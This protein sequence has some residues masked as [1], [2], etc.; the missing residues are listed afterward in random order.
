MIVLQRLARAAPQLALL[1]VAGYRTGASPRELDALVTSRR[2]R[3]E[4]PLRLGPREPGEAA[5]LL[6]NLLEAELRPSP[7]S[8]PRWPEG[9]GR[10]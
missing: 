8:R 4:P 3:G 10:S 7:P 1:L 2:E 6:A 9:G 5:V